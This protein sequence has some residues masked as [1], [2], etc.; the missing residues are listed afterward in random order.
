MFIELIIAIGLFAAW[1]HETTP[2]AE[3]EKVLAWGKGAKH[4]NIG[5]H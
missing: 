2:Y 5:S 3:I 1:E 4:E